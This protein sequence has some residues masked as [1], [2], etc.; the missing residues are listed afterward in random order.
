VWKEEAGRLN[1]TLENQ[2]ENLKYRTS[3]KP[4]EDI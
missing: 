2:V 1:E 4:E 3:W